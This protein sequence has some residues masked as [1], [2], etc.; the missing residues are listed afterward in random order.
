MRRPNSIGNTP[1]RPAP[2]DPDVIVDLQ[3]EEDPIG[4]RSGRHRQSERNVHAAQRRFDELVDDL[5]TVRVPSF[6]RFNPSY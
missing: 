6:G 3:D 1:R 2:R 4:P 5:T